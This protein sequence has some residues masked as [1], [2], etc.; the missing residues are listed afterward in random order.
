MLPPDAPRDLPL[1]LWEGLTPE[2]L[3]RAATAGAGGDAA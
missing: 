1:G 2:V 3:R